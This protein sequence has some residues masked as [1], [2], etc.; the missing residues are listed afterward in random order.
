MD[1]DEEWI[2]LEFVLEQEPD[3]SYSLVNSCTALDEETIE[4]CSKVSVR[5]GA[6]LDSRRIQVRLTSPGTLSLD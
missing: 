6:L 3:A 2:Q 5:G 1:A 4:L